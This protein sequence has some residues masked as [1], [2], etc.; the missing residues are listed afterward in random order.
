M[1]IDLTKLNTLREMIENA[2]DFRVPMVYFYDHFADHEAFLD[3]SKKIKSEDFDKILNALGQYIFKKEKVSII[4]EIYLTVK[5]YDIIHGAAFI[6]GRMVSFVY[7]P[8]A[9]IGAFAAS[10][11]KETLFGRINATLLNQGDAV[12]PSDKNIN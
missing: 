9:Q 5:G 1:K 10:M 11:P 12:M 3:V 7:F 8:K 6:E 4:N 2:T